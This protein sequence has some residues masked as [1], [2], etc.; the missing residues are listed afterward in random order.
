M[1]NIENNNNK[2]YEYQS[3]I[4][5]MDI[6]SEGERLGDYVINVVDAI[7]QGQERRS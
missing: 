6:I 4:Y 5:Y 3:G 1:S 7:K 2:H